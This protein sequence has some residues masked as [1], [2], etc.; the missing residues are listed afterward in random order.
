M[1]AGTALPEAIFSGQV[2]GVEKPLNYSAVGLAFHRPGPTMPQSLP[3]PSQRNGW[4][5]LEVALGPG[6]SS[7]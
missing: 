7:V 6:E 5:T 4:L 2:N 1:I 3:G